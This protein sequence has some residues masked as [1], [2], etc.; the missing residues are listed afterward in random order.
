M[1]AP[2]KSN[3]L[4]PTVRDPAQIKLHRLRLGWS[5]VPYGKII[6]ALMQ[7]GLDSPLTMSQMTQFHS[8]PSQPRHRIPKLSKVN[9]VRRKALGMALDVTPIRP[10]PATRLG[11]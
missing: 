10:G 2:L 8:S 3:R 7:S 1:T 5:L 4:L 6:R 11:A 9:Q